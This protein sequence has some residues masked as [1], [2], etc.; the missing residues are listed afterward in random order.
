M[1][2]SRPRASPFSVHRVAKS[3]L[4]LLPI[5][6]P[7]DT[8]PCVNELLRSAP[9]RGPDGSR[10]GLVGG[11]T[12][13]TGPF[14][15]RVCASTRR[16]APCELRIRWSGASS[17]CKMPQGATLLP[18]PGPRGRCPLAGWGCSQNRTHPVPAPESSEEFL[19]ALVTAWGTL[20]A[21]SREKPA[22][23]RVFMVC[24]L[25]QS[26]RAALD[27]C[28]EEVKSLLLG[29]VHPG[30]SQF[31]AERLLSPVRSCRTRQGSSR[32]LCSPGCCYSCLSPPRLLLPH[33]RLPSGAAV[34]G[35]SLTG[36]PFPPSSYPKKVNVPYNAPQR[37]FPH[38]VWCSYQFL[39]LA[40]HLPALQQPQ[41]SPL[42]G[43][44]RP[45]CL[46]PPAP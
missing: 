13:R 19:A 9:G 20:A 15:T 11:L 22:R 41:C 5:H 14:C 10:L 29:L 28:T 35:L 3:G 18:S 27:P 12:G 17:S 36:L 2:N 40:A 16:A 39:L 44:Q 38:P 7:A 4:R 26:L 25:R 43:A 42:L 6:S 45:L 34:H 21:L 46:S 30:R 31:C 33:A 24:E 23:A 1:S 32:S 8:Q 37:C